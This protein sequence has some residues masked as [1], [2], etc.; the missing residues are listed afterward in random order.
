MRGPLNLPRRSRSLNRREGAEV[1]RSSGPAGGAIR[2]RAAGIT[3]D[4]QTDDVA[5]AAIHDETVPLPPL[6]GAMGEVGCAAAHDRLADCIA[7]HR[8]AAGNFLLGDEPSGLVGARERARAGDHD[9][10]QRESGARRD[11]HQR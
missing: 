8:K 2:S 9:Q 6:V 10:G 3:D 1:P 5:I 11:E 7:T 4:P